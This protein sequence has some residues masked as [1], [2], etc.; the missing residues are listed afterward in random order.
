MLDWA[1]VTASSAAVI[2]LIRILKEIR[3]AVDTY[4]QQIKELARAHPDFALLD[5]KARLN[6][7]WILS[8]RKILA[9]A[10]LRSE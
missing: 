5:G 6:L 8:L 1:V 9:S 10:A 2:T 4:D 7:I 3:R